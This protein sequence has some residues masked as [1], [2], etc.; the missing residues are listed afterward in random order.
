DAPLRHRPYHDGGRGDHAALGL[1]AR[2]VALPDLP[3]PDARGGRRARGDAGLRAVVGHPRPAA[4]DPLAAVVVR[5]VQ[6]AQP[7]RRAGAA[8]ALVTG[9]DPSLGF[10]GYARTQLATTPAR[11]V[12]AAAQALPLAPGTFDAVVSG[13]VLNFVPQPTLAVA[14]MCR[15]ARA[16]GIVAA[17]V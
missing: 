14:E 17:Y 7:G 11:F 13:L 8:P 9:L 1:G 4:A 12:V 16:G 15:V 5:G 2:P 3:R 6:G 10:A